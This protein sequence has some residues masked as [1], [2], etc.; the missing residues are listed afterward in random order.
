MLVVC[1]QE[2]DWQGIT[3]PVGSV[4]RLVKLFGP[5]GMSRVFQ[6]D[7]QFG[8]K[9]LVKWSR[10]GEARPGKV[11]FLDILTLPIQHDMLDMLVD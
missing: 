4:G 5:C 3:V 6:P 1:N 10:L 11:E 8:V 2:S 9:A 7:I